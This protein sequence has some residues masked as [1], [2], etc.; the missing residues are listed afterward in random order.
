MVV[1]PYLIAYVG[2]AI[3]LVAVVV[4]IVIWAKMPIHV[5]WEL[6]PVAH[7]P[8]KA[9]YG[10]S[11]LEESEWWTKPRETSVLG[12]LKV[13]VPEILFLV[14]LK[15]HNPKMWWRSFPFHFGIYLV[16]GATGLMGLTGLLRLLAPAAL[17]G[18][19]GSSLEIAVV[20]LGVAGLALGILGAAGLL[21]QRITVWELRD[22][23]APADFFNLVLFVIV[24][25]VALVGFLLLNVEFFFGVTTIIANLMAFQLAPLAATGLPAILPLISAVFM[26][27][28]LAYIPMTHMS[29]FV[30]KYFAYHS[31]RW[32]DE[33]NMPGGKQEKTIAKAL[34]Q[35]V[36]WAA[37]H[38]KGEGKKTWVDLATKI[39]EDEEENK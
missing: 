5:R 31:I 26:S 33:P 2:I 36:S 19:L 3:F 16:I 25:G 37:P 39:P 32:N 34:N 28:L 22:Y 7:E 6:Y 30:G 27:L 21:H 17:E 14:A 1:V 15:E 9:D 4:R 12:E 20:G 35:P 38:I 18:A 8:G 24:F 23:S 11:Y 10:G 29:H 13:M